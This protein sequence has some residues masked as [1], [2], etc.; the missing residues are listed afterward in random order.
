[1]FLFSVSDEKLDDLK[2]K[3]RKI[4]SVISDTLEKML[5]RELSLFVDSNISDA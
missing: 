3:K 2:T 4:V 1:L 5:S